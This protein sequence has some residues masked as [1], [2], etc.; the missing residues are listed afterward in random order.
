M[1]EN[2][3]KRVE[4]LRKMINNE[5]KL[6]RRIEHYPIYFHYEDDGV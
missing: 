6:F 3:N 5:G 4:H 1:D 2:Y